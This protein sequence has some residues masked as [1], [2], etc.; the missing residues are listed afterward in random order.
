LQKLGTLGVQNINGPDFQV[1]DPTAVQDEARG[2]AIDDA[3]TKAETLAKQLHVRLGKVVSYNENGG[4]FPQPVYAAAGKAMDAA[5]PPS[6][7]TGTNETDVTVS[8]T[9]EIK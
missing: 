3:R 4:Y 7:P 5:T 2:K 1:D 9:Y 6:L 8:V